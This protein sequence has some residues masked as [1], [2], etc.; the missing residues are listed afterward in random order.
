MNAKQGGDAMKSKHFRILTFAFAVLAVLLLT[1]P[2]YAANRSEGAGAVNYSRAYVG[3][4]SR[5]DTGSYQAV[6]ASYRGSYTAVRHGRPGGYY[7]PYGRFY[8]RP[9][10]RPYYRPYY[11][12]YARPFYRPYRWGPYYYRPYGPYAAYPL[13]YVAPGF[14][15]YLSF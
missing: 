4:Y 11:R 3:N 14:S 5:G 9:Y 6:G 1:A 15:F 8:H 12:P 10:V 13:P 7:R 2:S